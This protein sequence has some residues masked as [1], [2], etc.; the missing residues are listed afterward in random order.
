LKNLRFFLAGNKASVLDQLCS[1]DILVYS[2]VYR[3]CMIGISLREPML[4]TTKALVDYSLV[5][6]YSRMV[7]VFLGR[8]A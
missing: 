8:T 1:Y 6:P 3:N 4:G 7:R 2:V 5:T